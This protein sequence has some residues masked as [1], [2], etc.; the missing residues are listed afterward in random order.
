SD[1]LVKQEVVVRDS[2]LSRVN[3]QPTESQSTCGSNGGSQEVL[4]LPI[5]KDS[6]KRGMDATDRKEGQGSAWEASDDADEVQTQAD[7]QELL[8]PSGR[9]HDKNKAARPRLKRVK[10]SIAVADTK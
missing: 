8:F 10:M 3:L 6:C 9:A 1:P 5:R 7:S 4:G 2:Q